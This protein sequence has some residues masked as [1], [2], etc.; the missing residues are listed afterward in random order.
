MDVEML[1]LIYSI[2]DQKSFESMEE[3]KRKYLNLKNLD[4]IPMVLVGNKSDLTNERQIQFQQ[5]NDLAKKFQIPFFEVTAKEE[6]SIDGLFEFIVK[7]KIQS[8]KITKNCQL[9]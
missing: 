8:K 7:N 4:A 5:G 2:T 9:M 6:D 1:I 3:Y